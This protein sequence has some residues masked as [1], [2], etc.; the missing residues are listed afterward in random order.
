M[1]LNDPN[2]NEFVFVCILNAP[3]EL[4]NKLPLELYKH[5]RSV[6][7][8]KRFSDRASLEKKLV[9]L[10]YLGGAFSISIHPP[11]YMT[12]EK[13]KE[14]LE[15]YLN[16]ERLSDVDDM[17]SKNVFVV[18][19]REIMAVHTI[20][21]MNCHSE[22]YLLN[23]DFSLLAAELSVGEKIKSRL[24]QVEHI[25]AVMEDHKLL[26]KLLLYTLT[27]P[28]YIDAQTGITTKEIVILLYLFI[29][30][31]KYVPLKE[32]QRFFQGVYSP[33]TVSSTLFA[34]AQSAHIMRV[35][36]KFQYAITPLGINLF[37]GYVNRL[38]N[39]TMTF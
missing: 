39:L 6:Q 27:N 37:A 14:V 19:D 24:H 30:R 1:K 9:M 22:T 20:M 21:A 35:A 17:L 23:R 18:T 8:I 36:G 4:K 28:E 10:S 11:G 16:D 3:Q 33:T 13:F 38:V 31:N 32:T 29:N 7:S 5:T 12:K 15:H 34:L 25:K 2:F 26:C